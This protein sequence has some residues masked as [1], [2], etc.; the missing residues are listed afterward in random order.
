L[1]GSHVARRF[2]EG[3]AR[4]ARPDRYRCGADGA[5]TFVEVGAPTDDELHVLLHTVITR[6]MKMLTRRGVL[7]KD[8]GQIWLAGPDADGEEAR[9]LRPLPAAAATHPHR[10]RA[11]PGG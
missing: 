1:G 5:P 3:D 11:P 7:V 6:L 8:M 9:A 10:L 4:E 2:E